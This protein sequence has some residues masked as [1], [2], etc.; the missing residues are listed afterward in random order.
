MKRSS[1]LLLTLLTGVST[2]VFADKIQ[3][4]EIQGNTRTEQSTISNYL[5]L[6]IGDEFT[7]AKEIASIKSL[8]NAGRFENIALDFGSG[9]LRVRVQESPL[10]SKITF[11]GNSRVK[12][13]QLQ[14]HTLTFAGDSLDKL[15]IEKD[16]KTIIEYYKR[17]GRYLVQVE[18]EIKNLENGRVAVI[19]K[20]KEGPKA[21][22]KRIN[23]VGNNSIS[24]SD[25]KSYLMTKEYSLLSIF[26]SG[27]TYDPERLEHDKE[28]LKRYYH[29]LGYADFN[30]I[31]ANAELSKTKDYFTVTYSVNEGAKYKIDDC[32]ID[33][34]VPDLKVDELSKFITVKT[35][36]HY[37]LNV[38]ES[39]SDKM[40]NYLS[41]QGYPDAEVTP[42]V[43][44]DFTTKKVS[45]SFTIE[46][47]HRLFVDKIIISGNS[48]TK[49]NIIRRQ[50]RIG[51][52]D[53]FNNSLVT[54]SE[55]RIRNLDF[56]EKVHVY[57]VQSDKPGKAN[58]IA[59]V[60][61]KSTSNIGFE[62]GYETS[63]GP[64]ASITF[65]ERNFV[66]T[67]KRIHSHIRKADK[68]ISYAVGI[69]EPYLFDKDLSLSFDISKYHSS[70][71]IMDVGSP[72]DTNSLTG[73]IGLDYA[74]S[75]DLSHGV[76]Y[77][78]KSDELKALKNTDIDTSS[79]K[80][81]LAEEGEYLTSA[82]GHRLTY[83]RT[84]NRYNPKHGYI[85]SATQE[86]AGLAG[87][88]SYV[89]HDLSAKFFKSIMEDEVTFRLSFGIGD[90]RAYGDNGYVRIHD[91][92][93]L[94]GY[95]LRGFDFGGIGPRDKSTKEG[96]NGKHYY[97]ARAEIAFPVGLPK[98]YNFTGAIFLDVGGLWGFDIKNPK[99]IAKD[100]IFETSSPRLSIGVSAV[101]ITKFAPLK[102]DYGIPIILDEKYDKKRT[103]ILFGMS[104]QF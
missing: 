87:D 20:I 8:Y 1:L 58:I 63:E 57:P 61:E 42:E 43:K 91:R 46:K 75:D 12:T 22:I 5:K 93:S 47:A 82:V 41:N 35:G 51:E 74:I 44:K 66:G 65:I 59:N 76:Y 27:D 38:I 99:D 3:R 80:A 19:F 73:R 39:I 16:I 14:E 98:D 7:K 36:E 67:G 6:K 25:L 53:I 101:W 49:D 70:K 92:F 13:S 64:F 81:I 17:S 45:V 100:D 56:F 34:K 89:K 4:I 21:Y 85:L 48:K 23:F 55:R 37:N 86:V 102:F 29:S 10:V 77:A 68:K 30:V 90:I 79:S 2:G 72:Y 32:I 69:T 52:G 84:N 78:L 26:S 83:D 94:G 28:I 15:K 24:S 11:T 54:K 104:T 96:L 33:N 97:T 71:G 60:E 88:I 18:S 103:G 95:S 9:T 50:M 40:Y 62:V 31:S